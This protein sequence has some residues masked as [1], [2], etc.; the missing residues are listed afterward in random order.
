MAIMKTNALAPC[1]RLVLVGCLVLTAG[2]V[3]P[4][5]SATS[6]SVD[7]FYSDHMVLQRDKPVRVSGSATAGE[8]VRVSI[9]RSDYAN[10]EGSATTGSDGRWQVTLPA[11]HRGGPYVLC[12]Q[13]GS[14]GRIEFEDVWFGEVWI[15]SGQSNMQY[16][17]IGEEFYFCHPHGA[18][19]ADAA[20]DP[21]LR[22][23]LVPHAVSAGREC[24]DFPGR[25]SWKP[26]IGR[27]AFREVSAVAYF[28]A[29][30]LR[31][32]LGPDVPVGIVSTSWGGT[33]IEP[34]IPYAAYVKG[35]FDAIASE[36]RAAR[37]LAAL[38]ADPEDLK[39][40]NAGL[41]TKLVEWVNEK[42]LKSAPEVSREA[43]AEWGRVDVDRSQW[44]VAPREK[45]EGLANPGI[46]W[47]RFE[48]ALPEKW[49]RANL[50][51]HVDFI[52]D[53]DETYFNGTK[54]G[55]TRVEDGGAYWAKSRDYA[56]RGPADGGRQVIAVRA[57]DHRG[58][59][60]VHGRVFLKNVDSGEVLPLDGGP[61]MERVEFKADSEKIGER[62]SPPMGTA[63]P[64]LSNG[65]PST[66][67]N[68]MIAPATCAAVRGAIW[69]QGCSNAHMGERYAAYQKTLIRGWRDAWN[70][71][72]LVFLITQLSAF[73]AHN[74]NGLGNDPDFW[75]AQEPKD[76]IGY[77]P[78]RKAQ[79]SCRTL[80]R[81]GVAC[82][83]DIGEP[84]DIHP[85]NKEDVGARLA[86]E[87]LR[88]A[89]GRADCLPGPRFAKATRNGAKVVIKFENLGG[90]LDLEGDRLNP[91]LVALAGAD[92]VFHW[93]EGAL[94]TNETLVVWSEAVKE[95]VRVQYCHSAYPPNVNLRRADDGYPVFPFDEEVSEEGAR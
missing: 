92:G 30:R 67:F 18:A 63:T 65:A 43:V 46:A 77:G 15:C 38:P 79:D 53:C 25:P 29:S 86:N 58:M 39:K 1:R 35:G 68:A 52:N 16:P 64:S 45:M 6:F 21:L 28:F 44:K 23:F 73:E 50:L 37:D 76:C 78:I 32:E 82:T 54:I 4:V 48:F 71:P 49:E 75:K 14:G 41:Q 47:Y 72:E 85:S 51:F 19:Y 84:F 5:L 94:D 90:G 83:I 55:E 88:I 93:G 40:L 26:M 22:A 89:Y 7:N 2:L 70:D 36:A 56:F 62:P 34:W 60:E 59:G 69:Y 24:T 74:P 3:L 13:S 95:P 17:M 81:T 11:R 80:P 8:S 10:Y 27:D 57:M 61:W 33:L 66:L 87:A 91:H 42:F 31:E 9:G 12:V 20:A